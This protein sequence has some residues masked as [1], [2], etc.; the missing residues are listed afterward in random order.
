MCQLFKRVEAGIYIDY[1]IKE[2]VILNLFQ[3]LSGQSDQLLFM[4][5]AEINS[6]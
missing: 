5:D 2:A 6:A 3:D 1:T 4:R